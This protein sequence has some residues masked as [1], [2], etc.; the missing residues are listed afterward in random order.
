M[1]FYNR[2]K[3]CCGYFF[4]VSRKVFFS[5]ACKVTALAC[6]GM[7]SAMAQNS[8]PV[9]EE[10]VVTA[11]RKEESLQSIP[12]SISAVS[13]M[14]LDRKGITGFEQLSDTVSGLTLSKP[15]GGTSASV[16]VRGVGTYGSS[17]A[18]QSVAVLI[19][20]VFQPRIGAAFNE[21]MDVDRVEVL[22]GPQGTLFGKN[23][24]AGVVRIFTAD[25]TTD[26]FYGKVQ[27]VLGNLNAR[28]ARGFVNIPIVKDTLALR[29][30]GFAAK[31]D[32]YT[33]NL[34]ANEDT[35]N[36]DRDGFRIKALW[37]VTDTLEFKLT[38][39]ESNDSS[40]RDS[41]RVTYAGDILTANPT[42]PEDYPLSLGKSQE[43]HNNNS[44]E[45]E[46]SI[47]KIN[48]EV[49]NHTVSLISALDKSELYLFDDRDDSPLL[50]GS[51]PFLSNEAA[52]E[53]ESHELQVV[54]NFNGA[55]NYVLG[56]YQMDEELTST[57]ILYSADYSAI[58]RP[59]TIK[60]EENS[61]FYGTVFYD[62]N[63][64]WKFTAGARRLEDTRVGT[65]SQFTSGELDFSE[66]TYSTKLQYQLD[67]DMMFYVGYDKGYKS[68]GINR[69]FG[70]CKLVAG[71][72]CLTEDEA[73]WDPETTYNHEVGMKS[74]WLDNRLRIN[75]ALFYQTYDDFQITQS[76]QSL[77]NVIVRNATEVD[78]KG[79]EADFVAILSGSFVLNG[80][81][82]YILSQYGSYD[83]ATCTD[84]QPGCVG[85]MQD[86]SD[87]YL[88]HAPKL[89]FNFGGE[90][91]ENFAIINNSEWFARTD[92]V[93]KGEQYLHPEQA[94]ATKQK[95]YYVVNARLGVENDA[96][97]KVTL[98]ANNLFDE[99]YLQDAIVDDDG[100]Y[101]TPGI[102]RTVGVTMD[103]A[104]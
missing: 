103:Y 94:E 48:W 8:S 12:T 53:T 71:A 93:Y 41:A 60:N 27:G 23:T 59:L 44:L 33:E 72:R 79:I 37:N 1:V 3:T 14:E 17:P 38:H 16:Y 85:G 86:L 49:A 28:E 10:I 47:L 52:T 63:E 82:S 36:V 39:E 83:N 70:R 6:L 67:N 88:D 89:S 50:F 7:P 54:S 80:S 32:G 45:T 77:S 90:Y 81:V 97:W 84:G 99:D 57:T 100:V 5:A 11:T 22:R 30:S 69:E 95:A 43:Q 101:W 25:P 61:A 4:P 46:R 64:S 66:T 68:G 19:D 102:E 96:G 58:P 26:S 9:L 21:L 76:I 29:V 62:I 74:E 15:D 18:S 31:R 35:R 56:Y 55:I 98:W 2:K 34:F 91:R 78:S 40:D 13:S 20:D 51:T 65:N 24:T 75:G 104:F 73:T 92:I 42:L 87:E